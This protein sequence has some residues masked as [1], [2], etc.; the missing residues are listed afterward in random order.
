MSRIEEIE[1]AIETLPALEFRRLA[2]WVREKDDAVWDAQ[3]DSDA[4]AGKLDFLFEEAGR[5][6]SDGLLIEWPL[7]LKSKN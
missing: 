2:E 4:A 7:K 3:I 1:A 5:E 6:A